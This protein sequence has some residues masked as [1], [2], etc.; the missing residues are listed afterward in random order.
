MTSRPPKPVLFLAGLLALVA[1]SS[2]ANADYFS[3]ASETEHCVG[4]T[5]SDSWIPYLAEY[6]GHLPCGLK[7][8]VG[9]R[10]VAFS[11]AVD[12]A[13]SFGLD[14]GDSVPWVPE[15]RIDVDGFNQLIL[16]WQTTNFGG[17]TSS[18]S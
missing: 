2:K 18:P 9:V 16:L 6:P 12:S 13:S 14:Q 17:T 7:L 4:E 3:S 1:F 15:N 5:S 8:Q 10:S 11:S